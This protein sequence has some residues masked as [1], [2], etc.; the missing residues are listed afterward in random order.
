MSSNS[1]TFI[2]KWSSGNTSKVE[3]KHSSDLVSKYVNF[4]SQY[5]YTEDDKVGENLAEV[6]T[7]LDGRII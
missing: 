6:K 2:D 7:F 3:Q 4:S 1:E 5:D